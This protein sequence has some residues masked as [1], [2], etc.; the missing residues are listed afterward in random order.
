MPA[1]LD[2]IRLTDE[3]FLSRLFM[4]ALQEL[5]LSIGLLFDK[6]A[7]NYLHVPLP[8]LYHLQAMC[9]N[10]V[11]VTDESP[12]DNPSD[13]LKLAAVAYNLSAPENAPRPLVT[14]CGVER[15][16]GSPICLVETDPLLGL[17]SIN[18]IAAQVDSAAQTVDGLFAHIGVT[19]IDRVYY[20]GTP[21]TRC[22][23]L[24][25]GERSARICEKQQEIER[26]S[27]PSKNMNREDAW[28]VF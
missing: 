14:T 8:L 24:G 7:K 23:G 16:M 25:C 27:S 19:E 22:P 1:Y 28:R 21:T 9:P 17:V 15:V 4:K 2:D 20:E 11:V 3:F 12:G 5:G 10:A 18:W 6:R 13:Q 26:N